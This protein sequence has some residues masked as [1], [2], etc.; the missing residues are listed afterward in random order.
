MDCANGHW[1]DLDVPTLWPGRGQGGERSGGLMA[2]T[3][4]MGVL[5]DGEAVERLGAGHRPTHSG[6]WCR[7]SVSA[8]Q[9]ALPAEGRG[10]ARE[11]AV[12][13]A[14]RAVAGHDGGG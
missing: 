5:M 7:C 2:M 14:A 1:R 4:R 9:A 6:P 3:Y 10:G 8:R 12:R 11:A 13:D